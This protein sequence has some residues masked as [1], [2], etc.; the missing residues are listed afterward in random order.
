MA[1]NGIFLS[2]VKDSL[3]SSTKILAF[4]KTIL[5]NATFVQ[6]I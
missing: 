1:I 6:T 3:I 2:I 4:G 5:K